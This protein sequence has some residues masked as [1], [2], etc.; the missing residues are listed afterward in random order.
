VTTRARLSA[1]SLVALAVAAAV[2]AR[3]ITH[4]DGPVLPLALCRAGQTLVLARLTP[5]R[6]FTTWQGDVVYDVIAA[7][8]SVGYLVGAR[9]YRRVTGRRWSL[10]ATALWFVGI[11]LLVVTLNSAV[12]VYDMTLF[13]A[14]MLEHLLLLMVVPAFLVLG[15]PLTMLLAIHPDGRLRRL[16][17]RPAL[18]YVFA[19][20]TAFASYVVVIVGTHLTGIM[21]YVMS[22]PWAGQVE[23]AA[24]LVV[25]VHFFTAAVGNAPVRWR[26][27]FPGRLLMVMLAMAVDAFVGIV[28][29]QSVI[30]I[31]TLPHTGW[32]PTP[33]NDTHLGGALMWVV[34]DGLMALV[35]VALY[36]AWAR[37]SEARP[38]TPGWYERARVGLLVS[39]GADDDDS[40]IDSDEGQHL[41]YN[42]WLASLDD[43]R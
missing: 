12:A 4:H 24:Y 9:S 37:H 22:H 10:G 14:H 17:D 11:G 20:P 38:E 15:R 29:M 35:P 7:V 39:R 1:A 13:S 30:P 32:G 16:V 2:V 18:S 8:A 19:A 36:I 31:A 5:S 28:L 21:G 42:R 41:A 3:G 26:L 27:S 43:R 6:A 40:D 23:H 33:L 25:G 34:G